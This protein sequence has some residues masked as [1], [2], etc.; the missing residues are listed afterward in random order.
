MYD[1]YY[2]FLN[3]AL[4]KNNWYSLQNPNIVDWPNSYFFFYTYTF[5]LF[6]FYPILMINDY[7]LLCV[8]KVKLPMSAL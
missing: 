4:D 2:Y 7:F 8:L 1:H 6:Y 5:S 3:N